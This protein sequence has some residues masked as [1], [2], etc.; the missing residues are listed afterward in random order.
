M[1]RFLRFGYQIWC[2]SISVITVNLSMFNSFCPSMTVSSICK[3]T[4]NILEERLFMILLRNS[5]SKNKNFAKIP[6]IFPLFLKKGILVWDPPHMFLLLRSSRIFIAL[7]ISFGDLM[8]TR[9]YQYLNPC[10]FCVKSSLSKLNNWRFYFLGTIL[11]QRLKTNHIYICVI[12]ALCH[13]LNPNNI[14]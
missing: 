11:I 9:M 14:C 13:R 4:W 1:A 12:M 6:Y 3:L 8:V 5:F 10:E 2:G 7:S